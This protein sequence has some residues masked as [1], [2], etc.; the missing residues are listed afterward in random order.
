MLGNNIHLLPEINLNNA[1]MV[2]GMVYNCC[3]F[4]QS[5]CSKTIKMVGERGE[6]GRAELAHQLSE[7][8]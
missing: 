3:V 6:M 7:S 8:H 1:F 5:N 4:W 2:E